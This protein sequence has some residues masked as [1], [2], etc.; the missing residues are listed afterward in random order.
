MCKEYRPR[1]TISGLLGVP[2]LDSDMHPFT[3]WTSKPSSC[4]RQATSTFILIFLRMKR[5]NSATVM[6]VKV[7]KSASWFI[8]QDN[9][10]MRSCWARARGNCTESFAT[11]EIGNQGVEAPT[12]LW[13]C[14]QS[15][16]LQL[17]G[18]RCQRVQ[19]L[20]LYWSWASKRDTSRTD[21]LFR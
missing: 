4:I 20:L 21:S 1:N 16:R 18:L 3:F 6:R 7:L 15:T 8:A 11:S 14:D 12:A 13:P 17:V 10:V 19:F 5:I 9:P 2:W